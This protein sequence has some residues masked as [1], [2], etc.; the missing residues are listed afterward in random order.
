[1]L[2]GKDTQSYVTRVNVVQAR[3]SRHTVEKPSKD[4]P[5]NDQLVRASSRTGVS[6]STVQAMW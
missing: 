5:S 6:C 2:I 3:P 4:W 1:M